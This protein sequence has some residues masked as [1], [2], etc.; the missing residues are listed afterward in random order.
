M[1]QG[2]QPPQGEALREHIAYILGD[3][4]DAT[5]RPDD[6]ITRAELAIILYRLYGTEGAGAE[7]GAATA[8]AAFDA[9]AAG[10]DLFPDVSLDDWFGVAVS[11]DVQT[12]L[13]HGDDDGTFRPYDSLTRAEFAAA[14]AN[15]WALTPLDGDSYTDTAGHWAAGYIQ[16]VSHAGFMQGYPDGDFQ[17]EARIAR[18]EVMTA[19]NRA[20]GR[21]PDRDALIANARNP[22]VDLP[23]SHWA[24]EQV[25]EASLTHTY[26][27]ADTAT[28]IATDT[29]DALEKWWTIRT[30]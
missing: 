16:A 27:L 8:K 26:T 2:E 24:F 25:L 9:E 6:T 19:L 4:D 23:E 13:L 12:G 1:G 30:R 10:G 20:L 18:A 3:E 22:Y 15:M 28:D 17:P 7:G 14:L 5:V 29:T 21:K 11:F